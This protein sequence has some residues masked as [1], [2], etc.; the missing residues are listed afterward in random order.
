[1]EAAEEDDSSE[2]DDATYNVAD[3]EWAIL[4]RESKKVGIT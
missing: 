3:M 1:M 2:E 4:R